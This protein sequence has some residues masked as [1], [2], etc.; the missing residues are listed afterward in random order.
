MDDEEKREEMYD[1][2]EFWMAFRRQYYKVKE[3]HRPKLTHEE[4]E[5]FIY[6]YRVHLRN[7]LIHDNHRTRIRK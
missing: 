7:P 2:H 3:G 6:K 4:V 5:E 1:V